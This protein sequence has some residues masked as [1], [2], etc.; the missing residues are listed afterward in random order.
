[1]TTIAYRDGTLAAD[2]RATVGDNVLG[3]VIKIARNSN[4]DLAGA[5]GMASYSYTFLKWFTSLETGEP[6]QAVKDDQTFD[7]GVIF[8]KTGQIIV[9]E[10]TGRYECTAPY[11]ALGSGRPE[12]LGAMFA[13]AD[14]ETAIKAAAAHDANTGGN[15]TV[16]R[17][18]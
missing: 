3:N 6:P 12:A 4:G 13:G 10:P 17:H 1:M 9:F 16:L 7:R 18:E 8:R 14:A 2:T 11:Y 15:I 5:A